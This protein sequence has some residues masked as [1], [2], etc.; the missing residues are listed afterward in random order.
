[1]EAILTIAILVALIW[2]GIL[3]A[4]GGLLAGC[5]AVLITVSCLSSEFF[6]IRMKPMPLTLDRVLWV[7][8]MIQYV[9]WRRFGKADPKRLTAVEWVL[10]AFFGWVL[11]GGVFNSGEVSPIPRL[12]FSYLMPLGLYWVARQAN[13][14]ERA[15]KTVL[16]VFVVFGAYLTVT[17]IGEVKDL[18]WL[19]YPKY[20]LTSSYKEFWGRARGP[21]LN[22]VG[23]GMTVC[24]AIL[25]TL[26]LWNEVPRRWRLILIV[27]LLGNFLTIYWTQTRCVWLGAGTAVGIFILAKIPRG[28][29]IPLVIYSLLIGSVV[30]ASQWDHLISFKRDKE[31]TAKETASSAELRPILAVVAWKMFKDHPI[32]G[33]GLC[34]Y[35]ENSK[36]YLDGRDFGL[37]LE[38]ARGYTQ[39]NVFLSLLTE[40]GLVGVGLFISLLLIW[41]Y[42]SLKLFCDTTKPDWARHQGLL[43]LA[44][45]GAYLPNGMFQDVSQIAMINMF[46]FF[47]A[48]LMMNLLL[49]KSDQKEVEGC[50]AHDRQVVGHEKCR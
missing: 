21:Y 26:S 45:L 9:L 17:A 43:F 14:T 4:R 1:M 48:G 6:Q 12:V 35:D 37:P 29:R 46:F 32:D 19:V 34:H 42:Y 20:I 40:T 16:I 23:N 11:V 31:L 10:A 7:V 50:H 25:S 36:Y 30:L 8:L 5:V 41:S 18:G 49:G 24:L 15:Y 44:F 39:H 22:P 38:K 33:V 2:G 3:L 47:E 27:L 13:L 28:K